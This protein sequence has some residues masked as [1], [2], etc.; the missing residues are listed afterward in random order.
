MRMQILWLSLGAVVILG[1]VG[2]LPLRDSERAVNQPRWTVPGSNPQQGREAIPRYGCSACHVVEGI[3]RATGRVGPKLLGI[4]Q[5]IYIG[6]VLPNSPNNL[7]HWIRNPRAFSP[8]TAMP[9]LDV[10]EQDARDI[11]AYLLRVSMGG[12]ILPGHLFQLDKP[13]SGHRCAGNTKGFFS[14]KSRCS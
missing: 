2:Y 7:I 3:R 8:G 11:A 6:G 14:A 4:H 1:A 9:D 10:S 12:L 5:Q 13:A